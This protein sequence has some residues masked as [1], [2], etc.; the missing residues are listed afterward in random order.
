MNN[1]VSR[2]ASLVK[3]SHTVFAMPFALLSYVYALVSTAVPFDWLLLVKILLC[4]VFARNA[5][6][7]FNR[8]ADRDI[9]AKN[10]R[11]AGRE[12]PAGK[13]TPRA[14][15]AFVIGNCVAFV[16]AAA[17]INCLALW[18]SPVALAVLLGYSLTKRF[19]AWSHVVLGLALAIAPVGAYIAVTGS[20][21]LFPVLLAVAVLTWT[22]GFD[23]LYSSAGRLFR[24]QQRTAFRPCTLLRRALHAHQYPAACVCRGSRRGARCTLP[25]RRLVLGGIRAF[26]GGTRRAACAL[27]SLAHRPDRSVVRT[28]ERSGERQLCGHVD[29]R[30]ADRIGCGTARKERAAV[31]L[32]PPFPFGPFACRRVSSGHCA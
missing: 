4:M 6:M 19:T 17:W 21:A 14:A 3:F 26:Y 10:P 5:A 31:I 12:I 29:C 1:V 11:T 15:L 24:P 27:P 20:V 16:A 2:Y 13:I 7:G 28:R 25:P 30:P 8:W 32:P 9:D 22:A 23:I 18:L